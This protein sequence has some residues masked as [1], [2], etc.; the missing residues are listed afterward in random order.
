M[1]WSGTVRCRHCYTS[2]HNR[3]SCPQLTQT[4]KEQAE[5]GSSYAEERYVK[6]TGMHLDGTKVAKAQRAKANP[7]RCTYCGARGHN[8]RTCGTLAENKTAYAEAAIAFR[9]RLVEAMRSTGVGIGALL[10]TERWGDTH[11]WMIT[12]IR[13]NEIDHLKIRHDQL[14]MGTNVRSEDRSNATQWLAFPALEDA[15]GE[16]VDNRSGM[17][18]L[19]GPVVLGGVPADFFH[20]STLTALMD[21]RFDKDARSCDYWDNYHAS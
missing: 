15:D 6:R 16:L 14:V 11:C 10:Q 18:T 13:W 20:S 1:S 21:D 9:R 3:R 4:L 8:R 5:N 19:V 2:G 17:S 12:K 7:R